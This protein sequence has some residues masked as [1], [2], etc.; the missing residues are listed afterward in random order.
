MLRLIGLQGAGAEYIS[1]YLSRENCSKVKW[2]QKRTLYVKDISIIT[3]VDPSKIVIA[4]DLIVSFCLTPQNG[5][6][7]PPF[8]G[9]QEDTYLLRLATALM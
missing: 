8:L 7:I 9:S 4:D 3:D 2:H 6:L 5:I 1:G